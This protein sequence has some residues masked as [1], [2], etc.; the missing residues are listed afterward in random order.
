MN[1]NHPKDPPIQ[2]AFQVD[3]NIVMMSLTKLFPSKGICLFVF[4]DGEAPGK[5]TLNY[6]SNVDRAEVLSAIDQWR[7][8]NK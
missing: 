1:D 2:K 5:S 3:M 7:A 8:R 4:G 6:I